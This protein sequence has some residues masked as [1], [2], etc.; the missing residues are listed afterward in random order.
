MRIFSL[1]I[2]LVLGLSACGPGR[3]KKPEAP[4]H[5][6]LQMSAE[7]Y[8]QA[9]QELAPLLEE[10]EPSEVVLATRSAERPELALAVRLG[11]RLQ[12][13]MQAVNEKRPKGEELWLTIKGTPLRGIPIDKPLEYG[14]ATIAEKNG[15]FLRTLPEAMREVLLG[16]GEFPL[17]FGMS[18]EDFRPLA[19]EVV[20]NY[21]R[22]VRYKLLINWR[23]WFIGAA[24]RDVRGY[25]YLTTNN[26]DAG[27]LSDLRALAAETHTELRQALLRIC[28][29]SLSDSDRCKRELREA[30]NRNALRGF[31]QRHFPKAQEL[32]QSYFKIPATAVRSD[33]RWG[34]AETLVP[35]QRPEEERYL[36]YLKTNIEEEFR[37][38]DWQLRLD[39]GDF[40]DSARLRFQNGVNAHVDRLG[41]NNI[42][43]DGNESIEEY[44]SQ[45]VIRHE[46]GHV[47]GLPDC[48]HEFYDADRDVFISYQLDTTDLMCSRAGAMN[49]RIFKELRKTYAK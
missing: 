1:L 15:H 10:T 28:L 40:T 7:E 41:G 36:V 42:V 45:W 5:L 24:N 13:W 12:R 30:W 33:V 11:E 37:F 22:A 34:D 38:G 48:Y 4:P 21:S 29:N 18:D 19:K 14:P 39:F 3:P 31:Y 26:L 20:E 46:F 49:E 35:F 9:L 6:D 17:T 2:F 43:M 44:S 25:H 23:D 32:W 27:R 8:R 47:L 16:T